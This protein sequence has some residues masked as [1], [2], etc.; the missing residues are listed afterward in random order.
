MFDPRK[1][2]PSISFPLFDGMGHRIHGYE[3]KVEDEPG[4]CSP[5]LWTRSPP[6][7][8]NQRR[9]Y[10]RSLSPKSKTQAIE[11]GQTELMEMVRTM[12]E[13]SYELTLKDIVEQPKV[14]V[15]EEIRVRE[16]IWRNKNVHKRG[17]VI[18]RNVDKKG[19]RSNKIDSGGL[20]LK[21]VF[22]TSLRSKKNN[23]KK[24]SSANNNSSNVSPRPSVSDRSTK[25]I[26]KD[27]WK[28]H[29]S[30]SGGESDSGVSSINSGSM[31]SS[32][33]SSSNSS[34]KSNSRYA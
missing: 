22:P 31:R 20:Y 11:R 34:S 8:P 13:S 4:I 5:P 18:S 17:S 27:W 14:D 32:G 33:S 1:D 26:D 9:N 19:S 2:Q 29:L 12:P 30:A 24:D 21:M 15:E 16:K 6:K 3:S 28:K 23:K 7:S 10:Y 25:N